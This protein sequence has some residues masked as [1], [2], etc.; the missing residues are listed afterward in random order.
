MGAGE[1]RKKTKSVYLSVKL[2]EG[3]DEGSC[4]NED[5]VALHDCWKRPHQKEDG[6]YRP[7]NGGLAKKLAFLI[8]IRRILVMVLFGVLPGPAPLFRHAIRNG[9]KNYGG[10]RRPAKVALVGHEWGRSISCACRTSI[11]AFESICVALLEFIKKKGRLFKSR[12][13]PS[14]EGAPQS[15]NLF[16]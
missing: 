7:A 15:K 9:S 1:G 6:G 11:S 2:F 3:I 16:P 5:I 8:V 10:D 12:P 4:G 14:E 13:I